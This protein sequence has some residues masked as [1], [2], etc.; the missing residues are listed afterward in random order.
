MAR[1]H[2]KNIFKVYQFLEMTI[3][4]NICFTYLYTLICRLVVFPAEISL[5]SFAIFAFELSKS[6]QEKPAYIGEAVQLCIVWYTEYV[7]NKTNVLKKEKFKLFS[8]LK[9]YVPEFV[10]LNCKNEYGHFP[11]AKIWRGKARRSR[12]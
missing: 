10:A 8:F 12:K 3:T 5:Q 1:Y 2:K 4:I 7:Q 9:I 11:S 6:F